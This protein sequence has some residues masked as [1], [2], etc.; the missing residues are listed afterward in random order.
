MC[1][2]KIKAFFRR[3]KPEAKGAGTEATKSIGRG[4]V[5][6]RSKNKSSAKQA[7]SQEVK[8]SNRAR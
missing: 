1:W 5:Q 7:Q 6:R 2:G 4:G 3:P 8:L